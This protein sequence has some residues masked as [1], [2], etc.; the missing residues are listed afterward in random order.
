MSAPEP[1]VTVVKGDP[2][3]VETAAII[4]VFTAA[5]AAHTDTAPRDLWGR[6]TDLHRQSWGL[7]TGYNN[8]G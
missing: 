6:A 3:D 7:P 8:R 2:T 4:Q 5:K 1:F